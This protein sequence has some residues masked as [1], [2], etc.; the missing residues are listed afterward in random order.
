LLLQLHN[1][2][3]NSQSLTLV[4]LLCLGLTLIEKLLCVGLQG[5]TLIALLCVGLQGLTLIA[6]LCV[7]LQ[8]LTL[9]ALLC[10]GLQGLT[11]IALLCLSLQ[12]PNPMMTPQ[13]PMCLPSYAWILSLFTGGLAPTPIRCSRSSVP[14]TSPSL[15]SPVAPLDR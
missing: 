13:H 9:I 15:L 14:R 6:L 4:A 2:H 10:V 12:G 3:Y 8:G 5:L 1:H 7:G 11:L